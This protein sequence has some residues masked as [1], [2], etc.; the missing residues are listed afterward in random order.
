MSSSSQNAVPD[1]QLGLTSE[2]LQLLRQGQ[3]AALREGGGS[4]SSRAA[5]RVS[6]NGLLLLDSSSLAALGRYFDNVMQNIGT[7]LNYLSDQSAMFTTVQ[8]DRAGNLIEVADSE[9]E[10]FHDI[11]RQIEELEVDFDRIAHVKEIV[12]GF[13][14]RADEMDRDLQ[15]SGGTTSSRHREGHHSSSSHRHGHSHG[16]SHKHDKHESSR[17]H[18]H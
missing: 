1:T 10:R 11:L 4:N 16:H 6:S 5:S 17:K 18:R 8:Y 12:R 14:Q 13:R 2:E 3:V 7:Q 9:I 15:R